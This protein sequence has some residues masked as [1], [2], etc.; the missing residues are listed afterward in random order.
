MDQLILESIKKQKEDRIR[1][2]SSRLNYTPLVDTNITKLDIY[3]EMLIS[4]LALADKIAKAQI[5]EDNYVIL[6]HVSFNV[7]DGYETSRGDLIYNFRPDGK[8]TIYNLLI[9]RLPIGY[10]VCVDEY[11][12]LDYYTFQLYIVWNDLTL[13]DK[14]DLIM[15]VAI[16][17]R[18]MNCDKNN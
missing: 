15:D 11:M 7:S 16:T 4:D 14:F 10:K 9:N 12:F 3:N 5:I 1:R 17:K 13:W 8:E 2:K 6:F 18:L